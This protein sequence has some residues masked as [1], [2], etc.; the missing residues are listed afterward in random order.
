[1]EVRRAEIFFVLLVAGVLTASSCVFA[2][3]TVSARDL[4]SNC[5]LSGLPSA[6]R[7][8]VSWRG[9]CQAG[10]AS[11]VGDV[12]A[13]SAGKPHYILRAQFRDG[14]LERREALRDCAQTP[15]ADDI[16]PSLYRLHEQAD[17][18]AT[19]VSP[20]TAPV[21]SVATAPPVIATVTG[22]KSTEIKAPDAIYSGAFVL[23]QKSGRIS[24]EGSVKFTDGRTYDGSLVN[25]VKSG[26]GTYVWADGQRYVGFWANDLPNGRGEWTSKDGERYVGDFVAGRREG[27]G[28]FSTANGTNYDGAWK[29]DQQSGRGKL[30]FPN[31]DI[32][33]GDF[34]AGARTGT[35]NYRQKSGNTYVGQWIAGQRDGQGI[36]E[37]NNGQRYEGGWRKDRKVGTGSMRFPDASTYDGPWVDDQATGQGDIVFAS[38]DTYTGAVRNGIPH[39]NGLFIWGS[40]DRF[41]GEFENG[42]PTANGEMTFFA[43][44]V[45]PPATPGATKPPVVAP[46]TSVAVVADAPLAPA[47]VTRASLCFGAFNGA[48]STTALRRFLDSF[49]DD[50]CG[51]HALAKQKIAALEERE[52]NASRALEERSAQ[53]KALLG[54]TVAFR[55]EFTSCV[56]GTGANCQRVTYV[57]DVKAKVR[58][59]DVQKRVA[60]VQV[61]DATSLGNEKRAPTQLFTEGRTAATA[62]FKT[63]VV[64]TVQSK[65]L[66]EIGIAF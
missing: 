51:R 28:V 41:E 22:T 4:Q 40:G 62:A 48:R 24:G 10:A 31:G 66:E 44:A 50:E 53:A 11:G 49:P 58:D 12:F 25:G 19:S 39:G 8:T 6:A 65:T 42:K 59:I 18:K 32:Y 64:G 57:F 30:T 56:T 23:D 29:A 20:S 36:E 63:R 15:C 61:S 37:W 52:K 33:E 26:T 47:P 27:S 54:A 21:A 7:L 34:V 9:D 2:Q 43:D 60:Q 16:P 45:G 35:G 38:G 13:F 55:Q 14:R 3:D 1:V 46:A 5:T 17:T